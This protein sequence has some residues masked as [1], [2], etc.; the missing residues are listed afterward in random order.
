MGKRVFLIEKLGLESIRDGEHLASFTGAASSN[1]QSVCQ[2]S[3]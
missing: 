3:C 1:E 2:C